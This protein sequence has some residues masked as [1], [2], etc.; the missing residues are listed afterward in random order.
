MEE[1]KIIFFDGVCNLCNGFIDYVINRDKNKSI[2]YTTL[3]SDLA[4]AKLKD[5]NISLETEYTTIYYY[6]N[7]K[8]YSKSS[9]ILQ[10]FLQLST[11]H[12]ITSRIFWIIPKFI[13]DGFYSFIAKNRYRFFGKKETCRLPTEQEKKQFL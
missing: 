11:F 5:Y 9:A 1:R 12:K 4:K 2:F 7:N 13:R 6:A 10:I 3:Q 8:L